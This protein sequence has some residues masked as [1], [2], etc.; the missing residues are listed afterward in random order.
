M[1]LKDDVKKSI[2]EVCDW[3][4]STG[5]DAKTVANL[6]AQYVMNL[7]EINDKSS[8]YEDKNDNQ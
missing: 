5:A 4:A 2:K 7:L 1:K 3:H 6:C 8:W